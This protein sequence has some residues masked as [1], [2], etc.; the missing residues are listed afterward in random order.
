MKHPFTRLG[1]VAKARHP[2]AQQLTKELIEWLRA[3]NLAFCVG[4]ELAREL[5]IE[6]EVPTLS[7]DQVVTGCSHVVVLGGDGTLISVSRYPSP[8]PPVVIGVNVGTLGF[9]T[10]I[11]AEELLPVLEKTLAGQARVERR[12]LLSVT[13]VSRNGTR[14]SYHVIN[15]AVLTKEALA[16]L[17]NIELFVDG[18]FAATIRG[19]GL[20]VSTPGGSTAY[21]LAA[22]GSIVHPSV[23]ALLVTPICPHSLTTRPLV[24]PD[25]SSVTLRIAT[26]GG[27]GA[28]FL[29]LDGQE[30]CELEDND[31]VIITGSPYSV[32]FA[33][34]PT[35]SYFDILAAKLHWATSTIKYPET[36]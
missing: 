11:T 3:R 12:P 20:I 14:Q 33:K 9:L 22:G 25:S 17:F 34:S 16:R 28:V 5:S 26:G 6:R 24:L 13:A 30:G 2:R 10:E 15:D 8:T 4:D 27:A 23:G 31:E 35:R 21:S 18:N 32:Y 1:I 19:D 29:T 7:R 36:P